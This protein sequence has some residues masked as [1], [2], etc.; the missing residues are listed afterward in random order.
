MSAMTLDRTPAGWALLATRFFAALFAVALAL[1]CASHTATAQATVKTPQGSYASVDGLRMY[2]EVH[3]A[4]RP[5]VLLHG[6]GS[7]VQ[8]TF[9]KLLPS[10]AKTHRIV[11]PE[12]QGHGHTADI[13]RPF[14][15]EQMADDTAALVQQLGIKEA[16]F[17][18][19]SNGGRVA[20]L[21]AIRHPSLVRRLIIASSFYKRGGLPPQ[22]WDGMEHATP[23]GM[24]PVLRDAYLAASPKPDLTLFVAKTKAMM[25]GFKDLRPEDLRAI[26]ARTLF[27]TGDADVMPPEHAMEMFRLLPH[28]QL[29]MFPGSG[30][31][32]YLGAAE[33]AKEGSRQP[34]A[35]AALIEEF[36]AAP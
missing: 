36:L 23:E 5:L 32:T 14:S 12:Q 17:F 8:T 11:G 13:D 6:G 15:F 21:V 9:G 29:A 16:D 10:L 18:G 34:E 31:G 4:G 27:M 35:A 2:Y 19:F 24:P 25:L 20:M 22:F 26:Q 33:S 30:H 28:A 1:G 3:G 7:T